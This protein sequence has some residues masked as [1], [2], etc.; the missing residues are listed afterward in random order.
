MDVLLKIEWRGVLL[1]RHLR[2]DV[3]LRRHSMVG[4]IVMET[5]N[6]EMCCKGDICGDVV[7]HW[8]RTRLLGQMSRVRIRRLP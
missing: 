1:R 6:G 4:C 8:Q 5:F 2:R 3:L 7:A